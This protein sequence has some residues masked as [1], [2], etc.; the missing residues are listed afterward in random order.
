MT[1]NRTFLFLCYLC[2][3]ALASSAFAGDSGKCSI[4]FRS[5]SKTS[6]A[7]GD[8]FEMHGIWG[9]TQGA[10]IPSINKGG[11]NKLEVLSWSDS[12]LVTWPKGHVSP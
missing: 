3:L 4:R 6:A 8:T 11:T 5:L 10:K 9:E 12:V 7:P 2:L 1:G